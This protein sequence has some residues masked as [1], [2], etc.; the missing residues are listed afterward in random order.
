MRQHKCWIKTFTIFCQSVKAKI[1][2]ST[3]LTQV[4]NTG[5]KKASGNSCYIDWSIVLDSRN[6]GKY[7]A[8]IDDQRG[9]KHI[10]RHSKKL[11]NQPM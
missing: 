5:G 11:A 8:S 7:A 3:C 10:A 1:K 9:G 2:R 4:H 6:S